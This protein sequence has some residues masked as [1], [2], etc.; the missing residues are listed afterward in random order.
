[1]SRGVLAQSLKP[2]AHDKVLDNNLIELEFGNVG[3]WGEGKARV[4]GEKP[5][6]ARTSTNNK[7]NPLN[8]DA[9]SENQ[10]RATFNYLVGGE[11]SHPCTVPTPPVFILTS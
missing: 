10:I 6:R 9:E 3:F 2:E 8:Y 5:L 1:M 4:P 11:L 7:L